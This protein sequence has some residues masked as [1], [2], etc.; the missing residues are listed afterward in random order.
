MRVAAYALVLASFLWVL[1]LFT[2]PVAT[3]SSNR[4]VSRAAALTY[5]IGGFVCHQRPERSFTRG[6]Q[7]M[8]VCA[9]C[10]GLYVSALAGAL[11]AVMAG[12]LA[13][14]ARRARWLLAV[15]GAAT[16]MTWV[17][18]F[19]GLMH[20][21]NMTRAVAAVP[22]GVVA[23]WLVVATLRTPAARRVRPHAV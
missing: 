18:E 3:K 23:A 21:S 19:A 10:T 8:P 17:G 7:P 9:R 16:V 14:D 22:L 20:P 1:A 12:G 5:T 4:S 2:A 13:L 11:L 6:G 15:A